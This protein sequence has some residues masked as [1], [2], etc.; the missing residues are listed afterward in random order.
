MNP[1]SQ[2]CS[3]PRNGGFA[4]KCGAV[5]DF[6]G[7]R[8]SVDG[9]SVAFAGL[10]SGRPSETCLTGAVRGVPSLSVADSGEKT[11]SNKPR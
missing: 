5:V 2:L 8:T 4:G 10:P 9:F 6:L 1:R 3:Y 7:I 11:G